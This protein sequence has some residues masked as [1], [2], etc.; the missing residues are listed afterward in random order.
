MSRGAPR[1]I[2]AR[3]P[4]SRPPRSRLGVAVQRAVR[5]LL[6]WVFIVLGGLIMVAGLVLAALPGH[7]GLPLLVIGLMVVLRNSIRARREFIKLQKR[8]SKLVFPV[9]RL[10][11]R[12]PEVVL[13]IWQQLLRSEKMILRRAGW[14]V[15]VR[16]RRKAKRWG[17]ARA[18]RRA[19]RPVKAKPVRAKTVRT[20]AAPVV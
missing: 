16:G 18:A 7:L 14:R 13:V 8:H 3:P 1:P 4:R 11:R 15:C 2:R 17:R 9:R 12:E 19:L 5:Q 6:R 10:M 20:K